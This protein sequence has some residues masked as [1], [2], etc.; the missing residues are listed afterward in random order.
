MYTRSSLF[1]NGSCYVENSEVVLPPPYPTHLPSYDEISRLPSPVQ[2]QLYN[3]QVSI[4]S[5]CNV[6]S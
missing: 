6:A 5:T 1:D 3:D 4:Y 2:L